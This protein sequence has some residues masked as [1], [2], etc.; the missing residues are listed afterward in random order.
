MPLLVLQNSLQETLELISFPKTFRDKDKAKGETV[1][2]M[3]EKKK[4]S[5]RVRRA[6]SCR[7]GC[8][9]PKA[10]PVLSRLPTIVF[11]FLLFFYVC[12]CVC[13]CF[14]FPR[15]RFKGSKEPWEA[16]WSRFSKSWGPTAVRMGPCFFPIERFL[17]LKEPPKWAVW[18]FP[19]RTVQSGLGFKTLIK[20]F[21]TYL[22]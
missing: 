13:V 16:V 21:A 3:I 15:F 4:A 9:S 18:D 11:L 5:R 2:L 14:F 20:N 7:R 12:V 17:R 6:S 1:D 22:F 19:S 10:T 8:N